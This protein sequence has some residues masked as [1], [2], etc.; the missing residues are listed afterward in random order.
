MLAV[1]PELVAAQPTAD[2]GWEI[3]LIRF[4]R[5]AGAAHAAP[6][7]DPRPVVEAMIASGEHVDPA[8]APAPAGLTEEALELLAWL[9]GPGVRLV[10][11]TRGLALPLACGGDLAQRLGE[12]RR[13]TH[14][15]WSQGHDYRAVA[16]ASRPRGPVDA[17][18]VTRMATA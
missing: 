15:A 16:D 14:Q 4:G 12:V 1:E 2:Q 5:L 6:G 18:L 7:L 8:A 11:S 13:S 10:R 9:D 17:A 3:H